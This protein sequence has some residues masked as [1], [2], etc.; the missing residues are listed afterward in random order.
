MWNVKTRVITSSKRCKWNHIK[1][2]QKVSEK[3]A[4]KAEN[5]INTALTGTVHILWV[6]IMLKYKN[7]QQL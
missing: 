3:Q 7:I 4:G 6:V 2:I 1:I 5:Q